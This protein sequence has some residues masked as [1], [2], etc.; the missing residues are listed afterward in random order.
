MSLFGALFAGVSGLN[1][2]AHAMGM[3]SDN[4]A[5]VNTVGYKGVDA[6]FSTLVTEAATATRHTPG[7]VNSS[8]LTNFTRQG[9]MQ[10]SSSPT[11]IGIAGSGFFVVN[12]LAAPTNT[13]GTYMFTRAGSFTPDKNG[14]LRNA[15]GLYLQGWTVDAQ[16]NIPANR[17]DLTALTTVNVTGLTGTAEPTT[18]V[19]LQA[20]VSERSGSSSGRYL[21]SDR[22]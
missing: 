8:P 7:G 3:I 9:L 6:R 11:D 18:A 15:A 19:T 10:S 1:A 21:R 13:T 4:I 16:G 17:S 12:E 5:N 20:N 2:N 14:N 22:G